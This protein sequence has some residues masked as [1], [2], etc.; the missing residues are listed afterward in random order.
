MQREIEAAL[1]GE[2]WGSDRR[3]VR[4]EG[5]TNIQNIVGTGGTG[6]YNSGNVRDIA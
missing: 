2:I 3:Y 1:T 6:D 4:G 5:E